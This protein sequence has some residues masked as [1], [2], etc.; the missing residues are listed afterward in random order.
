[1]FAISVT[2]S[3]EKQIVG[4]VRIIDLD[5]YNSRAWLGKHSAWGLHNGYSVTT[6][7]TDSAVNFTPANPADVKKL[8][9]KFGGTRG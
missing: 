2:M 1:M 6:K 4:T 9:E 3:D 7:A 5:D 8:A